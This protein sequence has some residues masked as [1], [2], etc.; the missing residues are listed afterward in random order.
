MQ[1]VKEDVKPIAS[2]GI[3]RT[4]T[5]VLYLLTI[6]VFVGLWAFYSDKSQ[7]V[8]K[9]LTQSEYLREGFKCVPLQGMDLHGLTGTMMT[10]DDCVDA[11]E[12]ANSTNVVMQENDYVY[13]WTSGGVASYGASSMTES[14][15]SSEWEKEGHTC[16]PAKK[17]PIY[18]STMNYDECVANTKSFPDE[19]TFECTYIKANSFDGAGPMENLLTWNFFPFEKEKGFAT[20]KECQDCVEASISKV[21]TDVSIGGPCFPNND[22]RETEISKYQYYVSCPSPYITPYDEDASDKFCSDSQIMKHV[23]SCFDDGKCNTCNYFKNDAALGPFTCTKT[24]S[25]GALPK[26]HSEAVDYYKKNYAPHIL[27][28]PLKKNAPFQCTGSE[29]KSA[30]EILSLSFSNTELA[31]TSFGTLFVFILYK[32]KKA[33]DPDFLQED[34]LLAKLEKL[35]KAIERLEAE[36]A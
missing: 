28:Q 31:F 6:G 18:S 4:L 17:D 21:A 13:M 1:T 19:K 22:V 32:L 9:S 30:L 12:P 2:A 33:N 27:C 15:S 25:N 26:T 24:T 8:S 35:E 34:E 5:V 29:P 7:W 14:V 16:R 36:K 3:T 23:K 11:V 10:Y 20:N